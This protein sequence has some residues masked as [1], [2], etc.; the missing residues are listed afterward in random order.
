MIALAAMVAVA[1][2]SFDCARASIPV[3]RLIC[4]DDELAALDRAIA[5]LY[6]ATPARQRRTLFQGQANWLE[7]RNRCA[8]R[9]CLIAVHDDRLFDLMSASGA[10]TRY[11]RREGGGTLYLLDAGGGWTV[12]HVIVLWF[13][14]NPGQVNDTMAYGHFRLVNGKARKAPDG[15]GCG[16]EIERRAANRWE[17]TEILPTLPDIIG[18]GGLNATATGTYIR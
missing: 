17:F 9:A 16:W 6:A 11:E 4:A 3:E 15:D 2:P 8:D 14:A 13:G 18:C 5:R 12:F 7:E 1:A 10:V